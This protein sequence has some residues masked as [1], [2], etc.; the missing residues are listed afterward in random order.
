MI[1]RLL[2]SLL[3]CWMLPSMGLAQVQWLSFKELDSA[4]ASKP[5][6]VFIEIYT[7]WCTYC[8]KMEKEVF[9]EP[10]I[11]QILND[12]FYAVRFNAESNEEVSFNGLNWQRSSS[13]SFHSL[14]LLF[15]SAN[16]AFAPP[17]LIFL[18]PE[19]E[20]E[21]QVNAYQSRKMLLKKLRKYGGS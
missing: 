16:V 1:N 8:K 2:L 4:I 18:S 17:M 9:P 14:A 13:E 11:A 6:P 7:D 20:L 19:L 15:K 5:K 10:A 12:D 3:L 21:E